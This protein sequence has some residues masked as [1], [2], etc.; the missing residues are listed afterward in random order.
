L[1]SAKVPS[2][3]IDVDPVPIFGAGF[4]YDAS[5]LAPQGCLWQEGKSENKV[6]KPALLIE[7]CV[8][9]GLMALIKTSNPYQRPGEHTPDF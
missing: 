8:K 4:F 5:P 3:V 1:A 2:G 6:A 9:Q 7:G